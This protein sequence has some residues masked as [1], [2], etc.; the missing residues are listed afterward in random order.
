ML[1]PSLAM[2]AFDGAV[3]QGVTKTK[4]LLKKSGGDPV[5]LLKLRKQHYDSLVKLNPKKY[6]P[7]YRGWMERLNALETQL[8]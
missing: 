4:Q 6:R 7:Y 5:K 1:P 3:N 2:V 8:T